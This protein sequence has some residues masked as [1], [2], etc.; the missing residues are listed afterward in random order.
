MYIQVP[1]L[2]RIATKSLEN[3]SSDVS[4]LSASIGADHEITKTEHTKIG[5][6]D[7]ESNLAPTKA[8]VTILAKGRFFSLTENVISRRLHCRS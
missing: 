7:R 6:L 4:A 3:I 8:A 5:C 1:S 2:T